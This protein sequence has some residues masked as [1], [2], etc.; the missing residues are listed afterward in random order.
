MKNFQTILL[1]VFGVFI[2]AGMAIFSGFIPVG[3]KASEQQVLS[4]ELTIW[5][6]FPPGFFKTYFDP[7]TQE[8]DGLILNYVS[9]NPDT[10]Y[11]ELVQALAAGVGP[12]LFFLDHNRIVEHKNKVLPVP[13]ENYPK[14]TFLNQ[15][16]DEAQLYLTPEGI[17]AFPF[18]GN[19]LVLYYNRDLMNNSF[20]L[21]PPKY[22][23]ELLTMAPMLTQKNETGQITRSAI[24]LGTATNVNHNKD[25]IATL[26]MQGEVPLV[27]QA[28]DGSFVESF[29]GANPDGS[30]A[31]ALRFYTS[32][33]DPQQTH[34]SWNT[35]LRNSQDAFVAEDTVMYIGYASEMQAIRSQNVNLNFNVA[36]LPQT[37]DGKLQLTTARM[38]GL[39]IS[40]Q[41]QNVATAFNLAVMLTNPDYNAIF[42]ESFLLPPVRREVLQANVPAEPFMRVFYNSIIISRAWWDPRPEVTD[43]L[44]ARM[45]TQTL[46][47]L[48][49]PEG[50]V[51]E[52]RAELRRLL[53]NK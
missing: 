23:D 21:E 17:L 22:W 32:F 20:I 7:L 25:I 28:T 43:T 1:I 2:A 29:Y 46:S 11:D 8:Y 41:S 49:E 47:R 16:V 15:F 39:A 14:E 48:Q 40:K 9:K 38:T 3:E 4:G 13:Y 5:G 35:S 37:R 30:I 27:S 18:L 33:A 45:I 53:G 44:F 51:R 50:T 52:A 12:D 19:P 6:T 42:S 10:Y 26:A 31:S 24:A 34:Y 36:L